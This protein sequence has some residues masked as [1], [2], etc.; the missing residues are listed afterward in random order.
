MHFCSLRYYT[1]CF[2]L[3]LCLSKLVPGVK[4]GPLSIPACST[5]NCRLL[6]PMGQAALACHKTVTKQEKK[7]NLQ[8]SQRFTVR[9]KC[10]F[11]LLILSGHFTLSKMRNRE[12]YKVVMIHVGMLQE[13]I[14][15]DSLQLATEL[16]VSVTFVTTG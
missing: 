15:N 2:C 10:V 6:L 14:F 5:C 8:S 11:I 7:P 16:L 4:I 9:P 13:S 12:C 3:W 1:V